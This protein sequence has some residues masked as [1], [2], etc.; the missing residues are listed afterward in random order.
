MEAWRILAT[1]LLGVSGLIGT[2]LVM[3][4]A[5]EKTGRGTTVAV[6]GLVGLT[7]LAVAAVLTLTTLPG[8]VTWALAGA[9]AL[10][11]SVLALAS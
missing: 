8:P 7:A 11:V 6:T 10:I 5:R 2:L 9:T 4:R 1:A 3:A